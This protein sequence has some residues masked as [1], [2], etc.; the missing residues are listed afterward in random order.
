MLE[1]I[2]KEIVQDENATQTYP[3]SICCKEQGG[4][5]WTGAHE[6]FQAEESNAGA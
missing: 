4:S 2:K 1:G 6:N 3:L 5:S